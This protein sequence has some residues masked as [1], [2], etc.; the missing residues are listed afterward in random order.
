MIG[1]PV[2]PIRQSSLRQWHRPRVGP[3]RQLRA[4][5]REGQAKGLAPTSGDARPS[6]PSCRCTIGFSK[7]TSIQQNGLGSAGK[8]VRSKG[9]TPAPGGRCSWHGISSMRPIWHHADRRGTAHLVVAPLSFLIER[10]LERGFKDAGVPRSAPSALESLKTIRQV[11]CR[12]DGP[13]HRGTTPGSWRARH[14]RK[15]LPRTDRRPPTPPP[16]QETTL[17]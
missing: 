14:V 10:M 17:E 16:G 2:R 11:Q 8:K 5:T 1:F 7:E 15:A 13:R 3:H 6:K 9:S 12:V 4:G